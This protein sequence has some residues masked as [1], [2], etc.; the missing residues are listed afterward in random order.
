MSGL[1]ADFYFLSD[2]LTGLEFVS[3]GLAP[4]SITS[5][6]GSG[7]RPMS[8][9][10]FGWGATRL[11]SRGRCSQMTSPP[12]DPALDREPLEGG[13][14]GVV[15]RSHGASWRRGQRIPSTISTSRGSAGG[16]LAPGAS[17]LRCEGGGVSCGPA[18][19]TGGFWPRRR[20]LMW[21]N[22]LGIS[23]EVVRWDV[24]WLSGG[25]WGSF[26]SA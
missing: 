24:V 7:F 10:P 1:A 18:K 14:R 3:S 9:G 19:S 8:T 20:R 21:C 12:A 5:Q 26:G 2:F 23:R 6:A 4:G 13:R 17:C 11:T 22:G 15:W 16:W 25:L